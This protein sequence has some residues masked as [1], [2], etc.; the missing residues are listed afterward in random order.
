MRIFVLGGTTEGRV[1]AQRLAAHAGCSVVVSCATEYGGSL[2]PVAENVCVL[3]GRLD[4]EV[5][6]REIRRRRCEVVVDATHPYAVLAS[7]NARAA[8]QAAGVRYMRVMRDSDEEDEGGGYGG[9]DV[10]GGAA[11]APDALGAP[12][13]GNER[14]VADESRG[15]GAFV[16]VPDVASAAA[17][18]RAHVGRVLLTTGS[19]DLPAFV[20]AVPDFAARVYVRVLPVT[21]SIAKTEEL[22]I[23]AS[24][25]IAMQGPF[26]AQLNAAILR[27]VGA[28]LLVTKASGAAGGFSQKIE[29]TRACGCDVVVISRPAQGEGMSLDQA[30]EEL[31]RMVAQEARTMD[32]GGEAR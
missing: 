19:K 20:D 5:M 22:G 29:A 7:E 21:A 2:V 8:A 14:A 12:R 10:V 31:E 6:E 24:H 3:D 30:C 15:S 11:C 25:V 26:S 17:C 9:E 13:A 18:V 4:A 28:T 1:I 23:P 32:D 27:E 16:R